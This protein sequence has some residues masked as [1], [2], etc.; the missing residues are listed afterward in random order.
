MKTRALR[1]QRHIR[2]GGF[3]TAIW[4][5]S[6]MLFPPHS[7]L[8]IFCSTVIVLYDIIGNKIYQNEMKLDRISPVGRCG[9]NIPERPEGE[10]L[11]HMMTMVQPVGHT[12]NII[13]AFF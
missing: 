4:W 12:V 9:E 8:S 3:D 5:F 2:R 6:P 1:R 7:N 13:R 10:Y 11:Y